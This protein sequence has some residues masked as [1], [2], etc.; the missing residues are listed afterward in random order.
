MYEKFTQYVS[1]KGGSSRFR[2]ALAQVV[3]SL[4]YFWRWKKSRTSV[5]LLN[6][7]QTAPISVEFCDVKMV[8]NSRM[9]IG[10]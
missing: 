4:H 2:A 1:A 7:L 9:L 6:P 5:Y 3:D 10:Q 8:D